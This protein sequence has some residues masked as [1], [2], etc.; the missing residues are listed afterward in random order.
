MSK[1]SPARDAIEA[2][3]ID[4]ICESLA[5]CRTMT[6]IAAHIG[7]S[8]GSLIAWI[9]EDA[10]RSARTKGSRTLAAIFWEEQAESVV[11]DAADEFELKKARELAQHYRW[12]AS[13]I[14]PKDYGDRLEIESKG[15]PLVII[16]DFTG[17]K[18][19]PADD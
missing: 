11:K 10:D 1:E 6:A 12:R 4:Q 19:E 9:S 7:V 13:K 15:M 16:K 18:N 3:G 14:A 17:R 2:Y 8:K 5:S